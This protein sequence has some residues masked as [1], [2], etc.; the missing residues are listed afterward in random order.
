ML[1]HFVGGGAF[2]RTRC[3]FIPEF[4]L[5]VDLIV[6]ADAVI[7]T[8]IVNNKNNAMHE[9]HKAETLLVKYQSIN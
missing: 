5:S 6:D 8:T 9:R 1:Q 7:S 4:S 2:F 3:I